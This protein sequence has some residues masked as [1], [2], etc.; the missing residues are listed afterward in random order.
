MYNYSVATGILCGEKVPRVWR[1]LAATSTGVWLVGWWQHLHK[2][3]SAGAE[4]GVKRVG[5]FHPY[6]NAG[7]GGEKV[8]WCAVRAMQLRYP[9]AEVAVYTGDLDCSPDEMLTRAR[10]RLNTAVPRPVRLVYLRRRRWVEAARYPCFTLLGQSLGSV[11]LGLE[12]LFSY[13]PDLYI[14]TM[15]YAFTYPLFKYLGGCRVASY[16]HY[17][18][19]TSD[20][21]RRV[22]SRSAAH[23]NR[24]AIAG[25][26]SLTLGKMLYYRL[27][28]WLYR[29]VGRCADIVMVNSSWT[30]EHI[31]EV[32]QCPLRTH[33]V[34]PPCDVSELKALPLLSD[35][36]ASPAPDV[37]AG[38]TRRSGKVRIVSVGQ[39]RPEK[40]H[41]MQLRSMYQLR[42]IVPEEVWDNLTL[43]IVGSCRNREDEERVQDMKDLCKHLSLENNVQFRVNISHRELRQELQ[44]GLVGL[45]SMWNEHF[46]IGIVEC[47]AAGLIMV[48]H[49][50]G[51][52]QMD[53]V[54][55]SEGSRTGF[56]ASDEDEYARAIAAILRMTPAGRRAIREAARAS[57]DRFSIHEF[58]KGFLR[59]VDPFFSKS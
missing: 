41:P 53:I 17:P 56:L 46:G 34:Y 10:Q 19:I 51:G 6:C 16:T 7:G 49:R 29:L 4:P 26:R 33:R 36:D 42:Q 47:M 43:V 25:S 40:D 57:V 58:E 3:R 31:N 12:A 9:T 39:F 32:W 59:A 27:F 44:Q 28:A 35:G 13:V 14:D 50:S 11:V 24:P 30:E 5:V 55:E 15:G 45:H 2:K 20:M 22:A 18:T 54:E 23:N 8:L 52:P 38:R 1:R 37:G 48:A 21:L